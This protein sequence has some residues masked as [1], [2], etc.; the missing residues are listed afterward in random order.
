MHQTGHYKYAVYFLPVFS[1]EIRRVH[2]RLKTF[3]FERLFSLSLSRFPSVFILAVCI[4]GKMF[5]DIWMNYYGMRHAK[6]KQVYVD[7]CS[8]IGLT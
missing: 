6:T 4:G 1:L 5:V 2:E 8:G 7:L 3:F